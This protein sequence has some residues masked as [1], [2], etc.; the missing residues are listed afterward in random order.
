MNLNILKY[1]VVTFDPI[2][3]VASYIFFNIEPALICCIITFVS[4]VST[5]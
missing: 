2:G 1:K 4:C 5:K 3:M